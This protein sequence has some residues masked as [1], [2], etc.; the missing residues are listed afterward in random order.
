[1][2]K[3]RKGISINPVA[4]HSSRVHHPV[5]SS[6]RNFGAPRLPA[7]F[8][9]VIDPTKFPAQPWQNLPPAT[10]K[11]PYH[12][13]LDS[14][15]SPDSINLITKSGKLVF[16]AVGDTGG[17]NTPTPIQ[18]VAS[19]MEKDFSLANPALHPSFYYHLGDVV[20]Y[21]GEIANYYPEFY[22]PYNT[23][24][25]PIVAIPGNHDG[26]IDPLTNESSLQGFVSNFCAPAPVHRPEAEDSPRTAMTQPNVYWTLETPLATMIGLYSNCP[27]GGEIRNDQ[28][29]WLESELT[30]A[31]KGKALIVSV[32]HPLYSAYGAHPGSQHLNS[33]ID[34]ACLKAKRVPDL[35]L[36]GHVHNY[37]RFSIPLA[38]RQ[39]PFIIAGAGGYNARLHMLAQI[40]HKSKLP[41][42]MPNSTASLE[43]FCDSNHGY[44]KIMVTQKKIRCDYFAVP[45]PGTKPPTKTLHPFDTVT[46]SVA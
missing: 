22:E 4:L 37:Q 10:G 5:P 36:S 15:L 9:I 12:L 14:I 32:H 8:Q 27:E 35:I 21:D 34:S 44:L 6:G 38:G 41:V 23:Y 28:I 33:V 24:P 43:S 25:A 30:I 1:M 46:V 3:S 26:D 42:Q 20:Y 40:F 18:N 17:V 13:S 31:P 11:P 2:A 29:T 19:F 39:I 7:A 16:H 45:D